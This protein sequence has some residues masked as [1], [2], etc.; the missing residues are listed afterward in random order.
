MGTEELE[1]S[2]K[3]GK[4]EE[5]LDSLCRYPMFQPGAKGVSIYLFSK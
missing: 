2:G 5:F 3:S 4:A 1:R